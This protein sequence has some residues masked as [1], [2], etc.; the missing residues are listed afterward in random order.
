MTEYLVATSSVH[1]TA[2]AADYLTDYLDPDEDS[3]VVVAVREP[4]RPVRDADD[5]IN[6]ARARFGTPAPTVETREGDTVPELLAAIEEHDPDEIVVGTNG[7]RAADQGVGSTVTE[8]LRRLRRPVVVVPLP[9]F[10]R[11]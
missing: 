4:G 9:S 8:L 3:L 5:A 11:P 1:V 2:A 6:V 10:S 7:G